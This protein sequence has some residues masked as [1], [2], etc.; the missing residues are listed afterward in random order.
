MSCWSI[1][2]V[3]DDG[4]KKVADNPAIVDLPEPELPT[5]AVTEPE[6]T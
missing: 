3:P 1:V 5:K 4:F 6:G 2:I